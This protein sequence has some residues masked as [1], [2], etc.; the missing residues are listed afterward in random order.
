LIPSGEEK[1]F[2][3]QLAE[4]LS[5]YEGQD[6]RSRERRKYNTTLISFVNNECKALRGM[7]VILYEGGSSSLQIGEQCPA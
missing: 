4:K 1:G 2:E 3:C 7:I 5:Y 6:L